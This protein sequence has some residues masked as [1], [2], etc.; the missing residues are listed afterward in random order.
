MEKEGKIERAQA[1]DMKG[2]KRAGWRV[3]PLVA[4]RYTDPAILAQ[5]RPLP[6]LKRKDFQRYLKANEISEE[7]KV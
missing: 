7:Y 5:L 1:Q 4:F 6:E 2:F 3:N